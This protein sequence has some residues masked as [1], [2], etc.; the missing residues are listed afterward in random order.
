M[1]R[2]TAS[3][4]A[5]ATLLV[6][7]ACGQPDAFE[8]DAGESKSEV[9]TS[10]CSCV[11]EEGAVDGTS[12]LSEVSKRQPLKK[13]FVPE[14]TNVPKEYGTDVR[15][16]RLRPVA[17][18]AF[19]QLADAIQ[20]ETG[21]KVYVASAYRDFCRQCQ[22]FTGYVD[23]CCKA[24]GGCRAPAKRVECT[25]EANSFSAAPGFSEHQLGTTFDTLSNESRRS[26]KFLDG[27]GEADRFIRERGAEYGFVV[28]YP[29]D[30]SSEGGYIY[31]P[32]HLRYVGRAAAS[33]YRA[34][35]RVP[36][37]PLTSFEFID[38]LTDEE[39]AELSLPD[40]KDDERIA[41]A[42]EENRRRRR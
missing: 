21:V 9:G 36:N 23:R 42:R 38:L 15:T 40:P 8:E 13:T 1:H 28:S 16:H 34:A 27:D 17:A 10:Q 31:E 29:R 18:G 2:P 5:V 6:S 26:D 7:A 12:L 11:A 37:R 33:A 4:L 24:A 3:V 14:L 25:E 19:V 35:N 20:A 22:L 32:W 30:T 41:L 39:K